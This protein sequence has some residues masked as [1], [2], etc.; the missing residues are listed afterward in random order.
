M[1]RAGTPHSSARPLSDLSRL[2]E[3][4]PQVATG[5]TVGARHFITLLVPEQVNAMLGRF[6]VAVRHGVRPT[7]GCGLTA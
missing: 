6:L 5:Q 7:T 4:T 1:P 2:Q 3:L